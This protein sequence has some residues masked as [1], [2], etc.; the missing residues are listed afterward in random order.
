[1]A[2]TF[3]QE[4]ETLEALDQLQRKI[5]EIKLEEGDGS[6]LFLMVTFTPDFQLQV[7]KYSTMKLYET[8]H[9]NSC[10]GW[11]WLSVMGQREPFKVWKAM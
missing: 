3:Q 10:F 5:L 6:P 7:D 2:D 4:V 1:M 8:D 9:R 11:P